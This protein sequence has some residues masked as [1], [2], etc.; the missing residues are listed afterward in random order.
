VIQT[1]GISVPFPIYTGRIFLYDTMI[2][3]QHGG[4]VS[5]TSINSISVSAVE[6][7]RIGNPAQYFYS[8]TARRET[9]CKQ[10]LEVSTQRYCCAMPRFDSYVMHES[11]HRNVKRPLKILLY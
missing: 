8:Q 5:G 6:I 11:C 1:V 4:H 9:I 7:A 3:D 10:G 2:P